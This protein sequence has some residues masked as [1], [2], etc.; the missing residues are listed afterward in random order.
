M[1]SKLTSMRCGGRIAQ[2]LTAESLEEVKKLASAIDNFIVLGG[3]TNMIFPD[4]LTMSPVIKLGEPFEYIKVEDNR[5]MAGGAASMTSVLTACRQY[6]LSGIEFMAGIPGTLGGAVWMNAGTNERGIMDR[7]S[8]IDIIEPAG[9]KKLPRESISYGYRHTGLPVKCIITDVCL[10]LSLS[11]PEDV[12]AKV[13]SYLDKRRNQPS[14]ASSGC[15]FKNPQGLSAGQLID[16][17]GLKGRRIGGAVVSDIHANFI[18]NDG[19]A[20]SA[21]VMKLIGEV[22]QEVKKQFDVQLEVEVR[23]ID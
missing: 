21:D 3:G 19:G 18:I 16:K 5:I 15:I 7:V 11:S 14:G 10:E 1:A 22:R 4:N 23:I 17:A 20:T 12:S 2:V 9:P 13:R 8:Y 6:G